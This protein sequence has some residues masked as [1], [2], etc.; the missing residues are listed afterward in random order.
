[1]KQKRILFIPMFLFVVFPLAQTSFAQF[2]LTPPN[3]NSTPLPV[4]SGARAIGQGGAFIAVADDATAASWNPGALMQLERPELSV[5]GSFLS[6]QQDFDPGSTGWSLGDEAVSRGDL[7]YASVAYPFRVFRKNFVAA[8][9][10]QQIYDFHMNLDFNQTIEDRTPP[11]LNYRQKINF[12]SQGG[13]GALTPAISMLVVPKLSVGVAINFYT[14]E[15]FGNYAWKQS[16]RSVGSGNLAGTNITTAYNSDTT[17]K[18]FQAI[19]VTTGI[20]WDIWEK[21]DKLLTFGAVY[22]TPYTADVDRITNFKS[23]STF[24]QSTGHERKNFEVDYPMSLGLGLGFRYNDALSFSMDATWTDWSAF[25]QEDE[26]GVKSRP[27]GG[28]SADR[29]ID[30]T[31]ALRCG[32]E[33]LIFGKKVIIPVRGGLFYDPRPSLDDP[34]DVYGFSVGS[35]ITFKRFS[36]DGAYQFRWANDVDGEDFGLSGTKFDLND[37]MFL[38]SVIVYF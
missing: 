28:A 10:Y 9:N 5:V 33:Y 31:Y 20:L 22:D 4:G 8:L 36:L 12:E 25:K 15:F 29:K 21:E 16:T 26:D 24:G 37:H 2:S 1:M 3:I 19:N 23:I 13:V 30:D 34:T 32:T 17:F 38:A 35:G 27:L 11:A 6:T 7:N 18:N 14:D